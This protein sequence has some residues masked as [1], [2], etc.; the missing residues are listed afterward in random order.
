VQ[1]SISLFL[2][3]SLQIGG[4]HHHGGDSI[5]ASTANLDVMVKKTGF[6]FGGWMGCLQWINLVDL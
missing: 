6:F 5:V 1:G 2:V 3:P 4:L